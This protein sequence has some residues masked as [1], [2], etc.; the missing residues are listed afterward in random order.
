[1]TGSSV[2]IP[3]SGDFISRVTLGQRARTIVARFQ[4]WL[5]SGAKFGVTAC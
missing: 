1:M 4:F 3:N 5:V 2:L